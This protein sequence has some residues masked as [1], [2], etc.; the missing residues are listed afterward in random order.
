MYSITSFNNAATYL[1]ICEN[2]SLRR[3]I[4]ESKARCLKSSLISRITKYS[5]IAFVSTKTLPCH[6]FVL[7]IIFLYIASSFLSYGVILFV[8]Y[9]LTIM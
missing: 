6:D 7:L 8:L 3:S 2:L 5:P 4:S 9:G 1:S